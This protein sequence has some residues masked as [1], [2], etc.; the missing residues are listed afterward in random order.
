MCRFNNRSILLSVIALL[1]FS[2]ITSGTIQ[3]S[4][5]QNQEGKRQSEFSPQGST[6]DCSPYCHKEAERL[7]SLCRTG[8]ENCL[9]RNPDNNISCEQS[10]KKCDEQVSGW[11][12]NC[13]DICGKSVIRPLK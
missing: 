12:Y 2:G 8:F 5:A 9:N 10:Y 11:Y 7:A 13:L 3:V 6:S 4:Q 1:V